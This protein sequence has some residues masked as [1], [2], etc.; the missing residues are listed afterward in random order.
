MKSRTLVDIL[1]A[2]RIRKDIGV[3]FID[4]SSD[5]DFLSYQE[6]YVS[7]HMGL[8]FLQNS[9]LK[10]GD[11]LVF[12]IEDNK[13]FVIIFW[14][15]ILGGIIPIP[16]TVGQNEEHRQKLFKVWAT[17][18]NPCLI[19]SADALMALK[20]FA[21]HKQLLDQFT[22]IEANT[23]NADGVLTSRENGKLYSPS[24]NDIAFI[25]FSS[26]SSGM[27]KGVVLTH[28]NLIANMDAISSAAK[29]GKSDSLISWMPLTHDMGVIG[30]HLN[31]VYSGIP[32]F[33][34]STSLFIRRPS[35]WLEKASIH[36]VTV[37]C[38]PN[39]G[40]K[41][42]LKH[43]KESDYN[44][45]LSAVR[46]IYNGAEPISFSLATTFLTALAK[47]GLQP[48]AMC[49]V[50]GLAEATLAVSISN[51]KGMIQGLE[52]DRNSLEI[53]DKIVLSSNGVYFVNVGTPVKYC[54]LRIAGCTNDSLADETVGHI[55]IRG[56]NVTGCYY[57]TDA[58]SK[59]LDGDGW[60]DTGDL[61]FISNGSLYV[62]GRA[63]DII[64]VNGQNYY[65]HDIERIAEAIEGI[66]LNRIAVVGCWN[67]EIEKEEVIAFVFHR[68]H[69]D[70]FLPV[71]KDLRTLISKEVGIQI[72]HILPVSEIP[73][74]TSG[75]LQRFKLLD[76][77]K[78]GSLDQ[79]KREVAKALQGS[80][81]SDT[82]IPV[83]DDIEIVLKSI[84]MTV[85][86]HNGVIEASQTFFDLGATSLHV[87]EVQMMIQKQFDVELQLEE[88]YQN[89]TIS[90][91]AGKIRVSDK[92]S[93]SDIETIRYQE[94]YSPSS[95]Q[96]RL[97]YM[98][99]SNKES[100]AYNIPVALELKGR[101]DVK[102]MERALQTMIDRHDVFR[103][104]F[105]MVDEPTFKVDMN[106]A[107]TLQHI[108]G[109]SGVSESM[110]KSLI[111]PFDL[112][113]GPLVRA[114]LIK[115]DND[116][117]IFFF[118]FHHIIA[119]GISISR[120]INELVVLY[121]GNEPGGPSI[122][123][124]DYARWEK[125]YLQSAQVT[126]HEAYWL[127]KLGNEHPILDLPLD[128][129]RPVVF[130]GAGE[131]MFFA[132]SKET[133]SRLNH[134]A[135]QT[136]C[137][138]HA[139][140]F[141]VYNILLFKYTG[142]DEM[143]IGIPVA[144]RWHPDVM[145]TQGMFV[146]SLPIRRALDPGES[147]IHNLHGIQRCIF[148]ALHYQKF[149]FERLLTALSVKRDI[150]RNPLFDTMFIYQDMQIP[151]RANA[152]LELIKYSF[153]PGIS[154][155][156]I[157]LEVFQDGNDLSYAIE[158]STSLFR[159]ESIRRFAKH[160][161]KI[162]QE[163]LATP[164]CVIADLNVLD[165]E[166]FNI[167]YRKFNDTTS[168]YPSNETIHGLFEKQVRS[169]PNQLALECEGR[170]LTFAEVNDAADKLAAL[171]VQK[172][173]SKNSVV[174]ILLKRTPEL[175]ISI[176]AVLKAGG[177]YVPIGEE[178]PQQ[179]IGYLI[180]D[181]K[182]TL[183]ITDDRPIDIFE[184]SFSKVEVV[185][186]LA[187]DYSILT[188]L[189]R[190]VHTDSSS[191]LAY[192]IYT[193]GTT[194]R[195]KGVMIEHR[196]LV[197]YISFAAK[198]YVNHEST[199]ALF[200]SISFDLTVTSIF[201]P[202]ITGNTIQI[203]A[204]REGELLVQQV[205]EDGKCN[206]VKLTPSHLRIVT[207]SHINV[208]AG[209]KIKCLIVGGENFDTKLA[210]DVYEK[211]GGHISIYNEYGPT[212][213]TVGCMIH[214]FD[215]QE[216]FDS[217]PIGVPADNLAVYILDKFRK[218][219]PT[220]AL[221]QLYVSGA[222]LA[223]GYLFNEALTQQRFITDPFCNGQKM[224]ETGD[225]A[226]QNPD[227]KIHYISRFD[228]QV[229]I[230]GYRIELSEI[231][232]S[233]AEFPQIG[234]TLVTAIGLSDAQKVLSAYYTTRSA[235][236]IRAQSLRDFLTSRLPFYMIPVHFIAIDHI[237]LTENGKVDYN[238]LPRIKIEN[239]L[240]DDARELT[241]TEK[242]LLAT[243]KKM[244]DNTEL[245]IW[246]NFFDLGGDSIK[247]VQIISRLNDQKI[248]LSVRDILTFHTIEQISLQAKR[249]E[250]LS[251]YE[252]GIVQGE[253][254]L[255]PIEQWFFSQ[256][257]RDPGYYNQSVLLD[258]KLPIDVALLEK[259]F[260]KL[261]EHH[262]GLRLNYDEKRNVLFYNNNHLKKYFVIDRHSV[263]SEEALRSVCEKIKGSFD[264][265]TDLLLKVAVI[266]LAG[267]EMLFMTAHHLIIDGIS[268]R[269]LLEDIY[270]TYQALEERREVALRKKTS[271]LISWREGLV[272]YSKS[273]HLKEQV[274]F[275]ND[276]AYT[277][278]SLPEELRA[279]EWISGSLARVAGK[280]SKDSTAYLVKDAHKTYKTDMP[281]LLN[282]ALVL[283]LQQWTGLGEFV[284]EQESH[285]RHLERIDA[286]RTIGWF[287]VMYPVKFNITNDLI[288]NAIREVKERLRLIPDNG[289][290]YGIYRYLND[291]LSGENLVTEIR[292]NYL[293][294][295]GIEIDNPLFSYSNKFSGSDVGSENQITAKLMLN[296]MIVKGE[297]NVEIQYC[298]AAYQKET[299]ERLRDSYF[300]KL[301]EI[302]GHLRNQNEIFFTP[303][304]FDAVDL[305]DEELK[306]LFQ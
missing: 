219:V 153:D 163:I 87:A 43:C 302:L 63:K 284:I 21:T 81:S 119:D 105:H 5:K 50:Y 157:S 283:S 65:P 275:W 294:Q 30:F 72:Q 161:Y 189:S 183:L 212:E 227:G 303:S 208:K 26:G 9:G 175:I 211:F 305:T 103:M 258:L 90:Q 8:H 85:L 77:Y 32:H 197:N 297:L 282:A 53:G 61:G 148:E 62:T 113:T 13:S 287:T 75:K 29:Y 58:I 151:Q 66:D 174:A 54:Q 22:T 263:S 260:T 117:H 28:R 178:L 242:I 124:K 123:Y 122:S 247:A 133:V 220:G 266:N 256:R 269:V 210:K 35:I 101:L 255:T 70:K 289:M 146:N 243:W 112:G 223:R 306:E 56:V 118:D 262:D 39:F 231:E 59:V 173:T 109:P 100:L 37:L 301:E 47:Y 249:S 135:K 147:F 226:K 46:I 206:V 177:C 190:G 176:L 152:D 55:Q 3:T 233:L 236:S 142:Q 278:F 4:N 23:L 165:S 131:K 224:Y 94:F 299:M 34:I 217:V 24:D 6:L 104:S 261:V 204:G 15:C 137:T 51:P 159:P 18:K 201:V 31:P 38:S 139:L 140:L 33:I 19:G 14:S 160:F 245:T 20:A 164:A 267:A 71:V 74:T 120:F 143:T 64:F 60:L 291:E 248:S 114:V 96:K 125:A 126:E 102:K 229:K 154:K 285:G 191:D 194:G 36:K 108:E 192:I 69:I 12:Q 207:A 128:Y 79:V 115:L 292:F 150:S 222:G 205:I 57:N 179:R 298:S 121:Q 49:P 240:I 225:M 199:F 216:A 265:A 76:D 171:L 232:N 129:P 136:G 234:E 182:T 288:D 41:Y 156:D 45:D 145:K 286:S 97:Y 277:D 1:K 221:G 235:E 276:M 272:A 259:I 230:N 268:W 169:T 274:A 25:Q 193:S 184:E 11:E 80:E 186:V 73:R 218:P 185:N 84:W 132:I 10:P 180:S 181:S 251:E 48:H 134:L 300:L 149:D 246:D 273:D 253:K 172:G 168:P 98:W 127:K 17:L 252:Q 270:T 271:S 295:F 237:P 155:F 16:L 209:C 89:P 241:E 91:L 195:P 92:V 170:K 198:N 296:L 203:Y 144:G 95:Q 83:S 111:K 196:S 228:Q 238:A 239:V 88:L 254:G 40:Y 167:Y 67:A 290:G 93:L 110:L 257:F 107:F 42:V 279:D 7:A 52:V 138:L 2:V 116:R 106:V 280:L 99:A 215:P 214:K 281:V 82:S 304:D 202:L 250:S 264:I 86:N 27:P 188:P 213:A 293:G 78:H 130:S 44:W 244:F 200:T 68:G 187:L 158:Y 166:E 162:I 141:S